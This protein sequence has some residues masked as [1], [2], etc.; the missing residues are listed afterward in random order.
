VGDQSQGYE[1]YQK[2]SSYQQYFRPVHLGLCGSG[3]LA[4]LFADDHGG[5][6]DADEVESEHGGHED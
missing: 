6:A 1:A 2:T 5:D 3:Q 4:L